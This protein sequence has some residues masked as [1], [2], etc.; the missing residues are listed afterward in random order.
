VARW[1]RRP[2]AFVSRHPIALIVAILGTVAV[3]L[4]NLYVFGIRG[5]DA[6]RKT[7]KGELF[8]TA[9]RLFDGRTM[10]KDGAILIAGRKIVAVAKQSDLNVEARRTVELGDA[11]LL[12]GFIDLHVHELGGGM[13]TGGVT[14]VRDLGSSISVFP[15]P[16]DRPGHLRLRA[17]GPIVSVPGGYPTVYWGPGIQIDVRGP[18]DAERVVSTLAR[19]SAEVIKISL[20]PGPGTWPMLS[21]GEVRAIVQEAHER[22]LLVTA[23]ATSTAAARR[24]L[25]GGVDE[26]AHMPCTQP[27]PDLMRELA[28]DRIPIVGTLH[29]EGRCPAK[30]ANARNFVEA[31]GELLYGSDFGNPGIPAAIDIEELR[32]MVGAGLSTEEA[33]KAATAGAGEVLGEEPLGRLVEGAPGD[34][35]AV[36]GDPFEDLDRLEDIVLL[37]AGGHA[38][39]EQGRINLPQ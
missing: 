23:H 3:T 8:V 27:A 13:L 21:L 17:A 15:L 30:L 11:T 22:D 14:T 5:S 12:P 2:L 39:I 9:D 7:V 28:Q 32:L 36:K 33:I 35:L 20:E 16:P 18:G 31:G 19:R 10:I 37:V 38:V 26:L 24:A 6:D 25:A 29:V 4:M 34:L 1:A